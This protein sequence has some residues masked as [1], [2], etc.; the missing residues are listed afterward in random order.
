MPLMK[1]TFLHF[2]HE[3]NQRGQLRL[4]APVKRQRCALYARQLPSGNSALWV[5]KATVDGEPGS[6]AFSTMYYLLFNIC[7]KLCV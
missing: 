6:S 7:Q 4:P 2:S 5:F 3:K 1:L